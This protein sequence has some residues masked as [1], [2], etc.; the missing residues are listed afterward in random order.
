MRV[1]R[2]SGCV[3]LLLSFAILAISSADDKK[4][5]QRKP[6]STPEEAVKQLSAAVKADDA[7]AMKALITKES[8]KD[9]DD[10]AALVGQG[11]TVPVPES[12][13]LL[14]ATTGY[15]VMDDVPGGM[16]AIQLPSLQKTVLRSTA[17]PKPDEFSHV[18]ALSGPDQEGRIAYIEDHFFVAKKKDQRHLLKTIRI[19]GTQDTE[20]FSRPGNAMWATSAAGRGEIGS[21]LALSPLQGRVA[22]LSE[23]TSVQ[24]PSALLNLGTVEIWDVNKKTGRKTSIKA[25]D[26][27]MAWFPDGNRLA[28]AKLVD[29]KAVAGS[30]LE[31]DD[32]G[33]SFRSWDKVPAVFVW[34]VAAGTESFLHVGWSPVVSFDGRFVL[35]SD[36]ERAWK[37]VDVAT[38][39]S[40]VVTWQ[41]IEWHYPIAYPAND[42]VLSWF[43][44]TKGSKIKYTEGL[45]WLP[46]SRPFQTLKL[47][48]LNSNEFQTVIPYIHPRTLVSFGEVRKKPKQ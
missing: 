35:V 45:S 9:F 18:H 5:A 41:G 40:S 25:L 26:D 28:Y 29:P 21:H 16:I 47:A 39:K 14:P 31:T 48:R 2:F 19:D 34:D 44:Q 1:A 32:F 3:G 7:D 15:L 17:P 30:D 24:M 33:K 20:L 4:A 11:R 46:G 6:A 36:M 37:R 43:P 8:R 13:K 42:V 22:F 12:L 23:T 38:G 10:N 27:V